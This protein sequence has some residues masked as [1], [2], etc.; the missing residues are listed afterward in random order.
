MVTAEEKSVI[1]D[2]AREFRVSRVLL[3]GSAVF[4]DDARDIDL[5]IEGVAPSLFFRLCG[6]LIKRLRRPVDIVDLSE[7]T[8]FADLVRETGVA[9]YG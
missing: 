9:I 8:P 2:C 6:E 4:R 1:Q 5:G 3:F 7:S